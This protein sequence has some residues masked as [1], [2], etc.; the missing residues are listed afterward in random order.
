[1]MLTEA[2]LL[3]RRRIGP[4]PDAERN[5]SKESAGHG[6][7]QALLNGAW[8]IKDFNDKFVFHQVSLVLEKIYGCEN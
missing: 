7:R 6:R 5:G 1:M 8:L 3:P 2:T 4:I